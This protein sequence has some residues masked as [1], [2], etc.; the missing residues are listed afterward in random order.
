MFGHSG[1]SAF[2]V[3]LLCNTTLSGAVPFTA[4][5]GEKDLGSVVGLGRGIR[6]EKSAE[7]G[8]RRQGRGIRGE[9]WREKSG[10]RNPGRGVEESRGEESRERDGRRMQRRGSRGRDGGKSRGEVPGERDGRRQERGIWGGME[11]GRGE[12]ARAGMGAESR[13]RNI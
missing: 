5:A 7:R 6:G 3:Q 8:G 10:E 1:G 11:E 13:G 12:V 2:Q 4:A 9:R